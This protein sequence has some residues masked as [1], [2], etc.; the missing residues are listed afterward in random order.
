MLMKSSYYL[1]ARKASIDYSYSLQSLASEIQDA[2]SYLDVDTAECYLSV[3][4]YLCSHYFGQVDYQQS[5]CLQIGCYY[6]I[7]GCCHL[8]KF[9]SLVQLGLLVLFSL[10][11]RYFTGI[12]LSAYFTEST[13]LQISHSGSFLKNCYDYE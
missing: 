4:P 10:V 7:V 5:L 9:D 6:L 1:T 2:V 3:I 8:M 12:T 13:I 11:E